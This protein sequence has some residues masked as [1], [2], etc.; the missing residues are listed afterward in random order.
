MSYNYYK[1][2]M[3]L[4]PCLQVFGTV[5]NTQIM[6]REVYFKFLYTYSKIIM[7]FGSYNINETSLKSQGAHRLTSIFKY[8]VIKM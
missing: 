7:C 3:K 2:E 5:T 6:F 8:K 1:E 4:K